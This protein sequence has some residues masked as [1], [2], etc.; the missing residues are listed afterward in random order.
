MDYEDLIRLLSENTRHGKVSTLQI[1]AAFIKRDFKIWWT[2]KFWLALDLTGILLL[3]ATYYIFSLIVSSQQVQEAGYISGGY[4]TFALL[5][6]SFQQY[7][8]FAMQSINASIREEQWNGTMET[9]LSS[10]TDFKRFLLGET[11]FFFIISSA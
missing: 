3:V 5:G 6:I 9:I 11:C 1:V 7:V 2:Y 4:F 8:F 10:A